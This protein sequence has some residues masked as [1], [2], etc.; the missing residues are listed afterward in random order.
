FEEAI[1]KAILAGCNL[2]VFS[3]NSGVAYDNEIASKAVEVIFK[4]VKEG[5]I[6]QEKINNSFNLITELKSQI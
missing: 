4:A 6:P 2:L 1:T 5:K 3:N